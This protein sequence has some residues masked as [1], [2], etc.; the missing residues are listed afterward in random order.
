MEPLHSSPRSAPPSDFVA[1]QL[2]IVLNRDVVTVLNEYPRI[3][4]A[5]DGIVCDDGLMGL[6]N[7]NAE[8]VSVENLI[9]S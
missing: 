3:V 6:I 9:A 1:D 5:T 4:R 2:T 7:L 8:E